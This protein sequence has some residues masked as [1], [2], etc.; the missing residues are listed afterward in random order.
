M[1]EGFE[2]VNAASAYKYRHLFVWY[3]YILDSSDGYV[4]GLVGPIHK[5]DCLCQG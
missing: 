5:L 4:C 2:K 1:Q 3:E